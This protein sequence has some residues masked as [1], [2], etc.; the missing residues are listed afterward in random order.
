L[1]SSSS[2]GDEA[3]PGTGTGTGTGTEQAASAPIQEQAFFR[4]LL[5]G[6]AAA[7]LVGQLLGEHAWVVLQSI[8]GGVEH[9]HVAGNA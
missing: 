4:G 7:D 6:D 9:G 3:R 5:A 1:R 8:A 2:T